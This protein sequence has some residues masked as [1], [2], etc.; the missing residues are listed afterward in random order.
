MVFTLIHKCK[1]TE[2][3]YFYSIFWEPV[4]FKWG[5]FVANSEENHNSGLIS[6]PLRAKEA[7]QSK[8]ERTPDVE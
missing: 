3:Y 1:L 2:G 7:K 6:R 8:R 4:N 5:S